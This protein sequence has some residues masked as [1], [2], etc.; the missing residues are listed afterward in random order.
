MKKT[1][2]IILTVLLLGCEQAIPIVEP[3]VDPITEDEPLINYFAD[4]ESSGTEGTE[5]TEFVFSVNSNDIVAKWI[6]DGENLPSLSSRSAIEDEI[7]YSF[8]SGTHTIGVLTENGAEDEV[9]ITVSP[10]E[11]IFK[12]SAVTRDTTTEF[13]LD[14]PI[15]TIDGIEFNIETTDELSITE[16][17]FQRIVSLSIEVDFIDYFCFVN[18]NALQVHGID[19]KNM[20]ISDMNKMIKILFPE[21]FEP[22]TPDYSETRFNLSGYDGAYS[23]HLTITET[24]AVIGGTRE[25]Y[26]DMDVLYIDETRKLMINTT[27][28]N[29]DSFLFINNNMYEF[30]GIDLSNMSYSELVITADVLNRYPEE[31]VWVLVEEFNP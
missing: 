16:T 12:L 7:T 25:Y 1:I 14:Y 24:Y 22:V 13:S 20:N 8:S 9:E 11:T 23:E 19:L 21:R 31:T 2:L 30:F 5:N 15:L 17:E 27:I 29:K 26:D 3:V 4:I 10:I 6:I 28:D 18:D